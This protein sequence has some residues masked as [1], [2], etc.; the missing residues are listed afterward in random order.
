[1]LVVKF[2]H[3]F[4]LP[5]LSVLPPP[6]VRAC[7]RACF[8][9]LTP[10]PAVAQQSVSNKSCLL[11]VMSEKYIFWVTPRPQLDHC[12]QGKAKVRI[13]NFRTTCSEFQRK[14]R[15]LLS[16][17]KPS[18]V[19]SILKTHGQSSRSPARPKLYETKPS[20]VYTFKSKHHLSRVGPKQLCALAHLGCTR[21][22]G[23][24]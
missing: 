10:I 1:M 24:S 23:T 19:Y 11:C 20:Y 3:I 22:A 17:A 15:L 14:F 6:C 5:R 7:V 4:Q 12:R 2:L 9:K 13:L 8:Q 16:K 18:Y 21:E